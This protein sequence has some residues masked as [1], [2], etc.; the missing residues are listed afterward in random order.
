MKHKN[1]KKNK[2]RKCSSFTSNE[3][4]KKSDKRRGIDVEE[5]S[6]AG[7]SSR[8]STVSFAQ[9]LVTEEH[10][11]EPAVTESVNDSPLVQSQNRW[12]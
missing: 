9:P 3:V 10:I 8:A 1:Q 11:I 2:S 4:K 7:S 6:S 5:A 12:I